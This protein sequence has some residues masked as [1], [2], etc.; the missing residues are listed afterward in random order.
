MKLLKINNE[1]VTV[2]YF[3]I[4]LLFFMSNFMDVV[5]LEKFDHLSRNTEDFIISPIIDS[6][7]LID[8]YGFRSVRRLKFDDPYLYLYSQQELNQLRLSET[9]L[10][11]QAEIRRNKGEW[12]RKPR[13]VYVDG[14]GNYVNK[15]EKRD[16][17]DPILSD[18]FFNDILQ[19]SISAISWKKMIPSANALSYFSD[20][21]QPTIIS[22]QGLIAVDDLTKKWWTECTDG[23]AIRNR[24]AT[25][26]YL[27]E[28]Y[29][30]NNELDD[31]PLD[32]MSLGCGTALPVIKSAVNLG[33]EPNL[34]LVDKDIDALE[35]TETLA[36]QL[37][38]NGNIMK[39]SDINIFSE[40]DMNR[41]SEVLN[42]KPKIIDL[43]GIFEYTGDNIRVNP[44][45]FLRN[46]YSLLD[47]GGMMIFGQM[48]DTRPNL[49]FALG[50]VGWPFIHV[51]S[52]NDL[53]QII[54]D[55]GI[56]LSKAELFLPNDN[57]Y[58]VV[59]IKK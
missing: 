13:T 42:F 36:K 8:N 22:E 35:Q 26:N 52:I 46:S 47:D 2:K 57:V 55:A 19:G 9:E 33:I 14:Q 6:E 23:E 37:F 48:L 16:W 56:D 11:L 54:L 40:N 25:L 30:I 32:W 17:G 12:L 38:F 53:K 7:T 21:T 27:V 10:S 5:R 44:S 58:S 20:P 1:R 28:D 41:L 49:D 34:I 24:N 43:M 3:T 50:V 4:T 31:K 39:F 15:N 18:I 45:K 29:I 51:R 59:K